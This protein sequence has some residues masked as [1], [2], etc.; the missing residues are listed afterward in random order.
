MAGENITPQRIQLSCRRGFERLRRYRAACA[1]FVKEYVGSFYRSEGGTGTT[2]DEPINLLFHTLRSFVPTLVMQNP[3]NEITTDFVDQKEYAMLLSLALNR[4]G[5]KLKMKEKLRAWIV[6]AFFGMSIM[7]V[8]IA[9]KGEMIKWGDL[10]VDL[11]QPYSELIDLEDFVMDPICK[12]WETSAFYGHRSTIPRQILLDTDGYDHDLVAALPRS[13]YLASTDKQLQKISQHYMGFM[14][15]VSIQDLVDVVELYV[16]E[17]EALVTMPD[18]RQIM[19]DKWIGSQDYYGPKEGPYIPLS[20]TQ[21][22]P[23][24]PFPIAPV[25][26]IF[27]IHRIANRVFTKLMDQADRQKDVLLY[28]PASADESQ[29]IVDSRDGD[30][31]ACTDPKGA[32]VYS[33][34]GQNQKNEEMMRVLQVW[35]NYMSGNPDQI[36]GNSQASNPNTATLANQIQMNAGVNMEDAKGIIYTQTAEVNR[37]LAWYLHYDPFINI[38]VPIRTTGGNYQ[39]MVLTPEIRRGDHQDFTFKLRPRSL[40]TQNPAV[41]TKNIID[42]CT[43]IIPGAATTAATLAQIGQQFNIENYLEAVATNLGIEDV[44]E[45]MFF[46]QNWLQKMQIMEMLGPKGAKAAASGP[47]SMAGA[48]QNGGNPMARLPAPTQAETQNSDAQAGTA[49]SLGAARSTL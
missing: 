39:Q 35:Y 13:M 44:V 40:E 26:V 3:I 46:D 10:D 1:F 34:G 32:Q 14:E 49:A 27:D 23:G 42:F 2:G 41:R 17:A 12:R 11:G 4:L 31:I 30:T 47:V 6:G 24:N 33:Y 15:M 16:P 21:P 7:K 19:F 38:P 20:F 37:R 48:Q 5:E 28:T 25:S 36:S 29:D 9:V 8:G 18:P 43:N 45:D 22:V